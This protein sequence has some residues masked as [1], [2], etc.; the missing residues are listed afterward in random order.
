MIIGSEV[1]MSSI[2]GSVI[3]MANFAFGTDATKNRIVKQQ[4]KPN[5]FLIPWYQLSKARIAKSLKLRG[6]SKPIEEAIEILVNRVP[7]SKRQATDKT[8]SLE[9]L[10]RYV[11][12][13]I[14]K[15][16][17]DFRYEVVK[18][19]VRS[20]MI[21]GVEV[22]VSPEVIVRGEID[23]ETV[24]GGLKI[25]I[26]KGDPFEKERAQYVS[27]TIYHY[28]RNEIAEEGEHVLPNLCYTIEIFG[29][30]IVQ[31]SNNVLKKG[32]EELNFVAEEYK[33]VWKNNN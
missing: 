10:E 24:I 26:S 15:I 32:L 16:L 22:S 19:V 8:V 13:K 6:D 4:L 23:G 14:P 7:T 28:L 2:R 17:S 21:A 12:M 11:T 20:T 18:P 3:Q 5:K 1:T 9:A 31:A 30:R 29:G 27:N 25:H 33:R